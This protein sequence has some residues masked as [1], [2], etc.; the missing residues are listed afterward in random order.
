M[1]VSF[2][3]LELFSFISLE[4]PIKKNRAQTNI[5]PGLACENSGPDTRCTDVC[6]RFWL[7]WCQFL[8][9]GL[10]HVALHVW[11]SPAGF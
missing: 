5:G 8:P 10:S 11:L 3:S 9:L 2:E 1:F 4:T 7:A 6:A